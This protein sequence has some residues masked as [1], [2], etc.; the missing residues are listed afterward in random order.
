LKRASPSLMEGGT[1]VAA[2]ELFKREGSFARQRGTL[3][4]AFFEQIE[5]L[6]DGLPPRHLLQ[7]VARDLRDLNLPPPQLDQLIDEFFV[8]LQRPA[9]A[10]VLRRSNYASKFDL[11]VDNE[12]RIAYRCDDQLI[13]GSIDRLVVSLSNGAPIAADIIDFKTDAADN[14]HE[15]VEDKVEYYRP[16]IAAYADA[17]QA[18]YRLPREAVK[19]RLLFVT[20]GISKAL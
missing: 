6:D 13:T 18:I 12:R 9:I 1:H 17:V 19:S 4:H 5:W 20:M 7:R 2:A 8:M 14:D 10:S 15:S 3:M 11:L 16:Q